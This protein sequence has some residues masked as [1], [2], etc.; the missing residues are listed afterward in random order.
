MNSNVNIRTPIFLCWHDSIELED[1]EDKI[2]PKLYAILRYT[3]DT[4]G[5]LHR[6]I[7][8]LTED[9]WRLIS[10]QKKYAS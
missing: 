10:E 7:N 9:D 6:N 2:H 8:E 3:A 4:Y 1:L 5:I